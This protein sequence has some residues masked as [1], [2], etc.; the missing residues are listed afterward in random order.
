MSVGRLVGWSVSQSV[1]RI[2]LRGVRSYT[3]ILISE[4]LFELVTDDRVDQQLH[5]ATYL[6]ETR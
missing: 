1:C 3:S 2:F 6:H 4:Q 5:W